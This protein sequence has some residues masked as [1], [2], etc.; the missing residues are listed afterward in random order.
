MIS[1]LLR[2]DAFAMSPLSIRQV[3]LKSLPLDVPALFKAS[4]LNYDI[5]RRNIVRLG[6]TEKI[7]YSLNNLVCVMKSK[8]T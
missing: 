8:Y 3:F 6:L 4:K 1:R 2:K 5:E 7:L